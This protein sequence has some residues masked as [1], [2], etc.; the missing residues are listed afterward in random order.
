MDFTWIAL[1][2]TK[3]TDDLEEV[4]LRLQRPKGE[5]SARK[6]L[7]RLLVGKFH[8]QEQEKNSSVS[9]EPREGGSDAW[10]PPTFG[11]RLL[12]LQEFCELV[13]LA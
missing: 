8:N 2:T 12:H 10:G 3:I 6:Y 11:E 4:K 13:K 9:A 1:I 7:D 5:S